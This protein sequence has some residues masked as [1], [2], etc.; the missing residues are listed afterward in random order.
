M[1]RPPRLLLKLRPQTSL[2]AADSNAN[3]RPLFDATVQPNELA[4][5]GDSASWFI[6]DVPDLGP[7]GWD[8]A[9]SRVSEAL[10]I[11]DSAIL[12]VEPDLAQSY[13][14]QNEA[15]VGGS[16][17]AIKEPDCKFHDQDSDA[18]PPGPGFAWHLRDEYS[19]LASARAAVQFSDPGRT[20]IAHIDTG[21]DPNHTARPMRMLRDLERNFVNEDGS[22]NNATDANRRFLFD[23]SGHGTGTS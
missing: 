15:N 14:D 17:F 12:F 10:G 18:R 21:Y 16:P 4:L 22:P 2:A 20:R 11:D 13:P 7:T 23:Q 3:L 9:H 19:Q 1:E 8:A 6:A 5:T